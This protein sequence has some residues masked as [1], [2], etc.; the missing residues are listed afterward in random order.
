MYQ[1]T[2]IPVPRAG[3]D[4]STFP[5]ATQ[6]ELTAEALRA[7][8]ELDAHRN[9]HI[10]PMLRF[11]EVVSKAKNQ[12]K[13]GN[14]TPWC[15]NK[16][17]RK[18]TWCSAHRRLFEVREDI[19]PA[20]AWAKET[21][22]RWAD[23][24]SV[25]RLLKLLDESKKAKRGDNPTGDI[26]IA[27][28]GRRKLTDVLAELAQAQARIAQDDADFVAL[29]DELSPE[30]DARAREL[31]SLAAVNDVGA[32]EELAELGRRLHWRLRD[33]IRRSTC[34]APQ[35]SDMASED[36]AGPRPGVAKTDAR[37]EEEAGARDHGNVHDSS[38][39]SA[40]PPAALDNRG[41]AAVVDERRPQGGKTL[42][43]PDLKN[44]ST[45]NPR[46]PGTGRGATYNEKPAQ[47]A[48]GR[49]FA[50]PQIGARE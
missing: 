21:S 1:K 17:K 44:S 33:L 7:L 43:L 34:G 32:T 28:K 45:H 18:P 48:Q 20:R 26:S 38:G 35:V 22:H 11:G 24:F 23:C 37:V 46:A 41:T 14:Y 10:A 25:E 13:Y 29:R 47:N 4:T 5:D 31:A 12:L 40:A 15:E 19:E 42:H 27:P 9:D 30:D 49:P 36:S 39:A 2:S 50:A 3:A 8:A 6:D 16:L